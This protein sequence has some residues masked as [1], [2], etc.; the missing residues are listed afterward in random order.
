MK[1]QK[2]TVQDKWHQV[3]KMEFR[4]DAELYNNLKSLVIQKGKEDGESEEQVKER[5]KTLNTLLAA[6]L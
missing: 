3:L 1:R 4:N 2:T 5:I 6:L